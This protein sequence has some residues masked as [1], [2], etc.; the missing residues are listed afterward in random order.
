MVHMPIVWAHE[1]LGCGGQGRDVKDCACDVG[2]EC[3][4]DSGEWTEILSHSACGPSSGV[5]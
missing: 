3:L 5:S 1:Q 2:A 4:R